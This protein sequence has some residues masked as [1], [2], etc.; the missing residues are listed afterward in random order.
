M[1]QY[2]TMCNSCRDSS[3]M[4]VVVAAAA[5][6]IINTVGYYLPSSFNDES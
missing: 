5:V 6:T 3:L 4:T 1:D 2:G